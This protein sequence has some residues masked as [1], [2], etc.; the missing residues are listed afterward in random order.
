[1]LKIIPKI[2]KHMLCLSEADIK[3]EISHVIMAW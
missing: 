2:S 1:M 3:D